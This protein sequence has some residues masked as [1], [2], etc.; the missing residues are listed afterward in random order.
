MDV[1]VLSGNVRLEKQN[2]PQKLPINHQIPS[3]QGPKDHTTVSEQPKQG[4]SV[5]I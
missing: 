2:S 4:N 1:Q 3:K 5:G